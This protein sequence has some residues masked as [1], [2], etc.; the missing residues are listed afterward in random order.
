MTNEKL[1]EKALV[2]SG[3]YSQESAEIITEKWAEGF[4]SD[5]YLDE[6]EKLSEKEI[7]SFVNCV[8][9]VFTEGLADDVDEWRSVEA[10][11]EEIF[12][13]SGATFDLIELKNGRFLACIKDLY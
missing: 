5:C 10:E 6:D 2:E 4:I 8:K 9:D 13:Y 12:G 11:Q 1:L 3:Y 7:E